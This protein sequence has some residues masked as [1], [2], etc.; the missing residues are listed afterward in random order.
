MAGSTYLFPATLRG[1]PLFE[2]LALLVRFGFSPVPVPL[3]DLRGRLH[4]RVALDL[5]RSLEHLDKRRSQ[6]FDSSFLGR[7]PFGQDPVYVLCHQLC[8]YQ[9]PRLVAT[10]SNAAFFCASVSR[11][12]YSGSIMIFRIV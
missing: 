3:E 12:L 4:G 1:C 8:P 10:F 2:Y 9:N 11:A 6:S 5:G 7:P